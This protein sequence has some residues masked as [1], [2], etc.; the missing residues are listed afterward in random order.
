MSDGRPKKWLKP[1]LGALATAMILGSAGAVRAADP[2]AL[3]LDYEVYVGGMNPV[4][5]TALFG[6]TPDSYAMRVEAAPQGFIR[7][8]GQWTFLGRA[9][10]TLDGTSAAPHLFETVERKP[11]RERRL[12]VRYGPDQAPDTVFVPEGWAEGDEVP[13]SQATGTA[14]PLGAFAVLSQAVAL[15]DACARTLPVFDGRRRYDLVATDGR[16]VVLEPSR[17]SAYAGPARLCRLRMDPIAGKWRE[18]DSSNFWRRP[19]PGEDRWIDVWLAAPVAGGPVVPVR[20][21]ADS[22]LGP[23]FIHLDDVR[24]ADPATTAL[25][26]PIR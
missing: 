19:R 18:S 16:D 21:H 12:E 2:P 5:A 11:E 14:D 10:G 23:V 13:A 17:R 1:A 22:K 24:V 20:L 3:E 26:P 15:G 8:F 9:W 7:M 25:L 4:G 6:L